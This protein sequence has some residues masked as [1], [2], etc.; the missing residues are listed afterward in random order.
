MNSHQCM[1]FVADDVATA[2]LFDVLHVPDTQ[3]EGQWNAM[4]L[5]GTECK[6]GCVV[7]CCV[8]MLKPCVAEV[9]GLLEDQ[10]DSASERGQSDVQE[11]NTATALGSGACCP[12]ACW[13]TFVQCTC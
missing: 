8:Q 13:L 5:S 6:A 9:Y 11:G 2:N 10:M 3:V 4:M 1:V 12:L 7:W